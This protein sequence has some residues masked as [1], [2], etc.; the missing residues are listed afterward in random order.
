[1]DVG[2]VVNQKY[3]LLRLVGD[4]GMGSV[5]E[6]EHLMLGT[7]VAIKVLHGEMARRSGL[8]DRF[9]QEARV[10]AQIKSPHVV[11]VTD[12]DRTPD[13]VA[14]LVMELLQGE[15][16]SALL[17]R[18]K[19]APE[20]VACEY[21][22]QILHALEAAHALGVIHRDLKP[23]NVFITYA[24]GKPV[25]K[26]IDFGIAKL[27]RTEVGAKNLTVAGVMMGTAEYMAPEQAFSADQ[28]DARADIYSVG[29]ML[30]ELIAGHRPVSGDDARVIALKVQRGE[31]K[32]LVH[33]APGVTPEIAGLV[34]RAMAPSPDVRFSSAAE[35]RLALESA[36]SKKQ[37]AAGAGGG[38]VR[39]VGGDIPRAPAGDA[40]AGPQT[41]QVAAVAHAATAAAPNGAPKTGTMMGAPV[42]LVMGNAA[43]PGM[44]TARAA[45]V[46]IPPDAYGAPPGPVG[47]SP[48]PPAY[49]AARSEPPRRP[50]K[51]GLPKWLLVLPALAG[52]LV[53]V[54]LVV[55][56]VQEQGG[57]PRPV[58]P[59]ATGTATAPT[60]TATTTTADTSTPIPTTTPLS[61]NTGATPLPTTTT[62]TAPTTTTTATARPDGGVAPPIPTAS[63]S[64]GP[65]PFVFPSTFPPIP[66]TMPSSFPLPGMSGF[67]FPVP[68]PPQ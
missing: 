28:V 10:S 67:P 52:A 16:L 45:P 37:R 12:V 58:P 27:R 2:Q 21:T 38:T 30:Y 1:V 3:K 42:E 40:P 47:M 49:V 29:V 51:K 48:A 59:V 19:K 5:F 34:H 24:A 33:A 35:M 6:A 66:S 46:D 65:T 8:V 26:L 56:Y 39:L 32:P 54:A 25:L 22:L 20:A 61:T 53:G 31:V 57:G 43:A 50:Q 7:H 17:D 14:Y 44:S 62:T 9:L 68:P 23:E 15:P 11:Q 13:G 63:A 36:T 4:G 64:S 55:W 18:D 41:A 60:A